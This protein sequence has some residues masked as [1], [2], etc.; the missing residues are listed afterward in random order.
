VE[1]CRKYIAEGG[2][3]QEENYDKSFNELL[4]VT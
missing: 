2:R 4:S 3:E 1:S